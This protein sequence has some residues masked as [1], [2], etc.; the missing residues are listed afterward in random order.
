MSAG[1]ALDAVYIT[2]E[3]VVPNVEVPEN[4][5]HHKITH[6]STVAM[7]VFNLLTDRKPT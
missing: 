6:A 5:C 2:I 3:A 4:G 7:L 1:T